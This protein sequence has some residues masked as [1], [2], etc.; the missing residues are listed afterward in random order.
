TTKTGTRIE[1]LAGDFRTVRGYTLLAAIVDELAFY[2]IEAEG[3]VR[4]DTEL[5]RAIKPALATVGGRFIGITSPYARKGF[6]WNQY[7]KHFGND[8]GSTLIVSCPSR[9]LN[10]CLPQSVVDEAMADDM[11]AAKSEYLGEFRDDVGIFIP[12]ELVEALVVED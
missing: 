11:A 8:Q 12:R 5:V 7:R 6:C 2:G 9:T 3:K 1:I 4:S 10:P